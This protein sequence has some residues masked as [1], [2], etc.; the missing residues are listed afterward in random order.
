MTCMECG[1]RFTLDFCDK[2]ACVGRPVNT[3]DDITTPHLPS[4]DF[5]K[6]RNPILHHRE[7]GM[8]L[9]RAEQAFKRANDLLGPAAVARTAASEKREEIG[10]VGEE[11]KTEVP[12][13]GQGGGPATGLTCACCEDALARPCWF[14]IDCFFGG[15]YSACLLR[16][17]CV[18][19]DF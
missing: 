19:L 7:I 8:I 2:S 3:R 15:V 12:N 17:S 18:H 5:V 4:H 14:C 16:A 6:I 10:V 11:V 1:H 13:E 9:K